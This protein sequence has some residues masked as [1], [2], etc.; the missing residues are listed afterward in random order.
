[1][2]KK[3]FKHFQRIDFEDNVKF[4]HYGLYYYNE[5][6]I[7]IEVHKNQFNGA[8]IIFVPGNGGS[9]K[10]VNIFGRSSKHNS[11][12]HLTFLTIL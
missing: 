9:Y 12:S 1:M 4:P 5:G 10:Q 11:I 6:R 2:Y 8:P 7:P 3:T